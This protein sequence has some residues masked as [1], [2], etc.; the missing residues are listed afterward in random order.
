MLKYLFKWTPLWII[1]TI[2]SAFLV[3]LYSQSLEQTLELADNQ[4]LANNYQGAIE[5]YQRVLFF[6]ETQQFPYIHE[7]LANCYFTENIL[8]KALFEYNV[9]YNLASIDSVKNELSFKRILIFILLDKYN[10]ATF[11]LLSLNDSLSEYFSQRKYFYQGIVS[12]VSDSIVTAKTEFEKALHPLDSGSRKQLSLAFAKY[13]PSR[14][15]PKIANLMSVFIPGAGQL[16]SG[17]YKNA[18]N[19]FILTGGLVVLFFATAVNYTFLDAFVSVMP[20]FQRYYFGGIKKAKATAIAKR[21]N[22]KDKMVE[23]VLSIFNKRKIY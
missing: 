9:A 15:N 14:P 4:Y 22:N 23:K 17:D 7:R 11:E 10:D 2:N 5:N 21:E 13:H 6:D 8:D 20:Y 18:A 3:P 16:Y 19:S 12:L 1:I